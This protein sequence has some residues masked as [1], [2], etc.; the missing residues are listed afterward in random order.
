MTRPREF[1]N[2]LR[3][4]LPLSFG[5]V[6]VGLL[7]GTV[8]VTSELSRTGIY[9]MSM[10]VF[11]GASQFAA[12]ELMARG[13]ALPVIWLTVGIINLRFLLYGASLGVHLKHLPQRWLVFLGFFLI[14]GSFLLTMRRY[15]DPDSSPY[16]HWYLTGITV[17]FIIAWLL[18]V[19]LG[20]VVG[21]QLPDPAALQLDFI[22]PLVFMVFLL[23]A[24][25]SRPAVF[26]AV[27]SA[28]VTLLANPLP[29]RLGLIVGVMAGLSAG[30]FAEARTRAATPVRDAVESQSHE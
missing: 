3:D 15:S 28:I 21:E 19:W 5:V 24:L 6:V 23:G 17:L 13:A 8:A 7:F 10:L 11:A 14:D 26:A 20:V 9:T 18:G 27:V 30:L 2:G 25:V 4:G 22:V 16:K 12:L 1:G 29:H